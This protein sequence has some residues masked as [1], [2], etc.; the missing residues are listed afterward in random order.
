MSSAKPVSAFEHDQKEIRFA[1][2]ERRSGRRVSESPS[3]FANVI[4]GPVTRV[5]PGGGKEA[6]REVGMSPVTGNTSEK[7]RQEI[8]KRFQKEPDCRL[9]VL[10]TVEVAGL[11]HD[12]YA[13][14]NVAFAELG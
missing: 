11:G 14:S 7:A 13:A 5:A 9:I 3:E 12:L 1:E 6:R 2:T 10:S 4:N 8:R